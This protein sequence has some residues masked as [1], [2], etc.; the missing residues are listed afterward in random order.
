[1]KIMNKINLINVTGII[2]EI[3]IPVEI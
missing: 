3:D 2:L 1:M